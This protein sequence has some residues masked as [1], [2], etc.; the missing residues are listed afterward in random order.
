MTVRRL[1]YLRRCMPAALVPAVVAL[2]TLIGRH[3]AGRRAK[4]VDQIRFVVGDGASE[5]EVKKL[6]NAYIKRMAWRAESRWH[7][8]LTNRQEISGLENLQAALI[9]GRGCI[10]SFFHHGDWEGMFGSIARWGIP[11]R[12]ISS[13]DVMESP[14][15]WLRQAHRLITSVPGVELVDSRRG[16]SGVRESLAMGCAVAVALDPPGHTCIKI[17]GREVLAS[18]GGSRIAMEGDIPVVRLTFKPVR[19]QRAAVGAITL[20]P[21]LWPR[22]FPSLDAL[23]ETMVT[24]QEQSVLNWPEAADQPKSRML[25]RG[26]VRVPTEYHPPP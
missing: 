21:P 10:I 26:L 18:S 1:A 13:S 19:G 2:R 4:A 5:T 7:P 11:V 20:E 17:F 6:A 22:D 3:H 15:P 24:H 9:E 25:N 14:L 16:S 8:R 23:M 12:V